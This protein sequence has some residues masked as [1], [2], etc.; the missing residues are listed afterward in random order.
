MDL[1]KTILKA[2]QKAQGLPLEMQADKIVEYIEIAT[3]L[4]GSDTGRIT[5]SPRPDLSPSRFTPGTITMGTITT[6]EPPAVPRR[7]T[8][9]QVLDHNLAYRTIDEIYAYVDEVAPKTIEVVLKGATDPLI[10]G[11]KIEKQEDFGT[12]RLMYCPPGEPN[13]PAAIFMT[14]EVSLNLPG[15]LKDLHDAIYNIYNAAPRT[16]D[17]KRPPEPSRAGF[18]GD[19]DDIQNPETRMAAQSLAR[20]MNTGRPRF[21][22]DKPFQDQLK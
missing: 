5:P 9:T 13:P 17:P 12:V 22:D 10:A 20:E 6:E 8:P 18:G 14:S 16:L 1:H 21:S 4:T 15:K 7:I 11:R 3:D 19:G 2:L